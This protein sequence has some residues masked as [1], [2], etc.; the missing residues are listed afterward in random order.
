MNIVFLGAPGSG[1]GT[2]A[3]II[4]KYLGIPSISTGETLRKEINRSTEMGMNAKPYINTGELVPNEIVISMI[5]DRINQIDCLNGFILDGFPRNIVQAK[6]LDD[7]MLAIGKNIEKVF[8]FEAPE[9][10]LIKRISGRFSCKDCGS[11]YNYFFKLP[12]KEEI[13]DN[14]NS[15][16][17]ESRS[18]DNKE[19]VKNRLEVYRESTF[20]LIKYYQKKS[21][22]ISVDAA[23][24]PALISKELT[25][26]ILNF[27]S[28]I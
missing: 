2:Q 14:C 26:A 4:A 5:K 8:N 11:I 25:E 3:T 17:F 13:C 28:T 10:V 6:S 21:L 1:K 19:I 20:E 9:D 12:I 22:L 16:R 18:D 23:K 7:V 24:V 15:N 27:F